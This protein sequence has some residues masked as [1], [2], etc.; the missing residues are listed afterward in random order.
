MNVIQSPVGP[1]MWA[2]EIRGGTCWGCAGAP[3][4]S[5]C[6]ELPNCA[7][8]PVSGSR[9]RGVFRPADSQTTMGS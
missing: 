3:H 8:N 1:V 7:E 5:S 9:I 2:V 4:E 6:D